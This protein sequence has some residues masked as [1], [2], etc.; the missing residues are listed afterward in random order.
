[1]HPLVKE[2]LAIKRRIDSKVLLRL[3]VIKKASA[4]EKELVKEKKILR[5]KV[6]CSKCEEMGHR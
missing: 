5:G 4:K 6:K 1:V 3:V 2:V